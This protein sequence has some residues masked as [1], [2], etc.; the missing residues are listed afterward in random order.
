MTILVEV[1]V[2]E[3]ALYLL[4]CTVRSVLHMIGQLNERLLLD[5]KLFFFHLKMKD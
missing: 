1:S 3:K 2:N 4:Y 5:M